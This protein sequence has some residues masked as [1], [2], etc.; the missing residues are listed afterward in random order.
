MSIFPSWENSPILKRAWDDDVRE[1]VREIEDRFPVRCY[2]Y[3]NHGYEGG[4]PW[5]MDVAISPL[6]VKANREQEEL[7]DR[8]QKFVES[9]IRRWKIYYIIYW[10]WYR[11]PPNPLE[12]VRGICRPLRWLGELL[13]KAALRPPTRHDQPGLRVQTARM[14][15]LA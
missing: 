11:Y 6:G 5:S 1:I 12:E 3:A 13:H 14:R 8:I 7:G 10:N 4:R 2:T 9:N 15:P